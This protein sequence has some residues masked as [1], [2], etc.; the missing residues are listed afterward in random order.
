VELLC[1]RRERPPAPLPLSTTLGDGC[2]QADQ[3]PQVSL[4]PSLAAGAR[5]LL[6]VHPGAHSFDPTPETRHVGSASA[7]VVIAA[8]GTRA[9]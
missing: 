1:T 3:L 7:A 5:Q 8:V 6:F 2:H 4:A 9:R